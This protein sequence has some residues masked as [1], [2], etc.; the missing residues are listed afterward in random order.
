MIL[1]NACLYAWTPIFFFFFF[2]I[3]MVFLGLL[4]VV[5]G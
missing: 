1:T 2:F 4:F 3:L 5:F